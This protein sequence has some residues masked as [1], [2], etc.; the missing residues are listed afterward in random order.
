LTF[1]A[2]YRRYARMDRQG[3]ITLCQVR[4]GREEVLF[5]LPTRVKPPYGG[6]WLSPDGRFLAYGEGV[7]G[8]PTRAA[9]VCVWRLAG[10]APEPHFEVP[11]GMCELALSFRAD[12]RQLAVGHADGSVSVYDLAT[13]ER[14]RRL[15]AGAAP[16][17]LAFHPRDDRLAVACGD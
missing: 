5:T 3:A 4:D 13:G 7:T 14:V 2:A 16:V 17:H 12:G 11:E 8:G 6:L 9:R 10:P 15:A 1:D